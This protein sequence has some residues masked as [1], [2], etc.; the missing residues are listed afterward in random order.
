MTHQ[1]KLRPSLN[2]A[3]RFMGD[4]WA[5]KLC[6]AYFNYDQMLEIK[7]TNQKKEEVI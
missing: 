5:C 2:P 1:H 7:A 6:G 3:A 4:K